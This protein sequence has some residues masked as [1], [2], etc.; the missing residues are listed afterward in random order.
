MF[1]GDINL[2]KLTIGPETKGYNDR[3]MREIFLESG[4]VENIQLVQDVGDALRC[5][6]GV[7]PQRDENNSTQR[8]LLDSSPAC[9]TFLKAIEDKVKAAVNNPN[10]T[11]NSVLRSSNNPSYP[12]SCKLKIHR[13]TKILKTKKTG[14]SITKPV[15]ATLDEIKKNSRV[16]PII[17]LHNGVYF[18]DGDN[19][20]SYGISVVATHILIVEDTNTP[21]TNE[22][23]KMFQFGAVQMEE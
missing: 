12:A 20:K 18:V 6:F 5:P 4:P 15:D 11:F 21:S 16:V 1:C 3:V 22:S 14:N 9:E 13:N 2:D 17:K 8:F 10:L 7:E 23:I 19:G